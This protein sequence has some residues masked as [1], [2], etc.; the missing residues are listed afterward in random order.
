MPPVMSCEHLYSERT[1]YVKSDCTHGGMDSDYSLA[2]FGAMRDALARPGHYLREWRGDLTLEQVAERV[3]HLA[4]EDKFLRPNGKPMSMTH[5]TLSRIER[6]L[7]P[8]NQV[9]LEILA[10]I[11]GTEPASL[12]MRNPTKANAP[13]TVADQ[14]RK[15]DNA[16][17]KQVAAF[18]S[19]IATDAA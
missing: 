12:I 6:G 11:Y 7:I 18:I 15:L 14:V 2:E 4:R 5:A 16:Q 8:Y 3:E 10:E 17:L 9:L 13:W 19:A 1:L